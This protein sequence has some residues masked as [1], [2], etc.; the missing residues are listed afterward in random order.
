M[1]V[2][3]QALDREGMNA[4]CTVI[5]IVNHLEPMLGGVDPDV[6]VVVVE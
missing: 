6:K 3:G 5:H 1:V 4:A 2:L